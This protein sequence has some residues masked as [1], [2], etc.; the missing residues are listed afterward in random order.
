MP[1]FDSFGFI[2][3]PETEAGQEW[4]GRYCPGEDPG[5]AASEPRISRMKRINEKKLAQIAVE[6]KW[7]R[8]QRCA[9]GKYR[10]WSSIFLSP[11][12]LSSNHFFSDSASLPV[13]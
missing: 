6:Q 11:I 2:V 8:R 5:K 3:P 1:Y 10:R 13:E 7:K 4:A 9:L 12:F